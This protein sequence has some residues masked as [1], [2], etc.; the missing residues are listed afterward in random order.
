[1]QGIFDEYYAVA[2]C[3]HSAKAQNS[4][5]P[6]R[7]SIVKLI[8]VASDTMLGGRYTSVA[9]PGIEDNVGDAAENLM[10]R[11]IW[12]RARKARLKEPI[13]LIVGGILKHRFPATFTTYTAERGGGRRIAWHVSVLH[14]VRGIIRYMNVTPDPERD[15]SDKNAFVVSY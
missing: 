14:D 5:S 7:A 10:H 8:T 9:W 6:E 4:R 3:C 13:G 11:V 12:R 2:G 15:M 1:M